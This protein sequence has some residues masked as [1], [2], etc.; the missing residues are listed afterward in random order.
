[1]FT[2]GT[3]RGVGGIGRPAAGKTGTTDA[4]ATAWFAGFTPDLA[5]AVSI[6]DPRGAQDHKLNDVTIGGRSY[7]SV[8]G[9][10]IPGPIWNDTMMAALKG[11]P[12]TPF[13]PVNSARF[14]GCGSSCRPVRPAVPRDEPH[15]EGGDD[16]AGR[17]GEGTASP[18]TDDG[19]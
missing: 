9:A 3:M 6:G 7:G 17:G 19:G 16:G 14:G 15:D 13:T 1:M 8:F 18:A 12:K 11:T 4:Q 10:T 2:K 5:G